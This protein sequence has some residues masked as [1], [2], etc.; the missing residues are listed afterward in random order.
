[1]SLS[2]AYREYSRYTLTHTPMKQ[3]LPSTETC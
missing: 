2:Q 1:M 3:Q